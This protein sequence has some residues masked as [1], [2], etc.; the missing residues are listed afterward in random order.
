MKKFMSMAWHGMAWRDGKS[1]TKHTARRMRGI[2][3][4]FQVGE[5]LNIL[6]HSITERAIEI[7]HSVHVLFL[8]HTVTSVPVV[9]TLADH[10]TRDRSK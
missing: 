4:A 5:G 1:P 6:V 8:A 2:I 10:D 9:S 7:V 3:R